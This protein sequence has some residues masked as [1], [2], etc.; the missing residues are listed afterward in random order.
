M[1]SNLGS[2]YILENK[3]DDIILSE[4]KRTFK[5]EFINRI[6]EIIIFNSLS[7]DTIYEIVDKIIIDLQNRLSDKHI[8]INLSETAKEY[9]VNSSYDEQYGARPIKRF[10]SRNIESLIANSIIND[11][12]SINS[13]ILIDVENDKLIL[14]KI[15]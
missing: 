6:D 5:P 14:K 7:K 1:T 10:I 15:D 12:I 8:K 2:E 4:L 3:N 11:E 13:N 9:I